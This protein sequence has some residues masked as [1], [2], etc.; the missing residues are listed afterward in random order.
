MRGQTTR[1]LARRGPGHL[2][3]HRDV[4]SDPDPPRG[5]PGRLVVNSSPPNAP[6]PSFGPELALGRRRR[7]TTPTAPAPP[8]RLHALIANKPRSTTPKAN[9]AGHQPP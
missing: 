6:D 7:R 3:R 1:I 4:Q 8:R 5:D 9:S 2:R